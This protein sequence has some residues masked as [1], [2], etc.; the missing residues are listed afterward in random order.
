MRCRG[1]KGLSGPEVL[2]LEGLAEL[3]VGGDDVPGGGG[4]A[5]AAGDTEGQGLADEDGVGLP[6]LAP[7][8]GHGHPPRAGPLHAG[9]HDVA[10]ARHVGDQH[11]VEVLEPVDGE[12]DPSRPPARH[13]A[14]PDISAN[15]WRPIPDSRYSISEIHKSADVDD[16]DRV[17]VL[18]S[19]REKRR[20]KIEERRGEPSGAIPSVRD[21]D[22][23]G[24]VLGDLEEHGH[25]EV[26]VGARRVAPPTVVGGERVVRRAEV[27][28]RDEDGGAPAV[29][30]P[31]VIR[32]LDL[33]A[34]PA[35][36]PLVEERRAQRRRLHP[37]PLA[38][39]VPVPTRSSCKSANPIKFRLL[40]G[41]TQ[42]IGHWQRN[43]AYPL[44]RTR[45]CRRRM[46]HGRS[47]TGPRCRRQERARPP[48]QE[49][50]LGRRQR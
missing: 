9:A 34:R 13:P 4:P 23:A 26:E 27:G 25:G 29:A 11:Q 41:A 50:P 2:A 10:G 45:R 20:S 21:G 49:G 16:A 8:A 31:R 24:A 33:E 28:S 47:A 43:V 46:S 17:F 37:V 44:S 19:K 48:G 42:R 40:R 14:A 18:I 5:V 15:T 39:Q 6:V 7:V 12:P 35:A 32:A 30:P 3:P 1:G 36:L 38:V 22:D